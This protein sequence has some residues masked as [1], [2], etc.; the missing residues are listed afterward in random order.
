[1]QPRFP[2]PSLSTGLHAA[3]PFPPGPAATILICL[4]MASGAVFAIAAR[5]LLHRA[6]L[7]FDSMRADVLAH[8][9]ATLHFALAWWACCLFALGAFLVG[10]LCGAATHAIVGRRLTRPLW[11]A[12]AIAVLGLAAVAQ[13]RSSPPAAAVATN[14]A[15]SLLVM[16][17]SAV[18]ALLGAHLLGGIS[19]NPTATPLRARLGGR[20]RHL[21]GSI[22]CPAAR[23]KSEGSANCG[24]PP[25]RARRRHQRV[26]QS[27]SSARAALVTQLAIVVFAPV[28]VLAGSTVALHLSNPA[29]TTRAGDLWRMTSTS[30]ASEARSRPQTLSPTDEGGVTVPVA[31]EAQPI[32]NRVEVLAPRARQISIAI[33]HGAALS[34]RD[35]TFTKGYPQR[36]AAQLAAGLISQPAIPLPTAAATV[37]R[38]D[39]FQQRLGQEA[40][41]PPAAA[42]SRPRIPRHGQVNGR[43]AESR[44]KHGE[45]RL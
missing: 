44:R 42:E 26:H 10:P 6:G 35:L 1:M 16:I 2:P 18:L 17:G 37:A 14:A 21:Q 34:E 33:G 43:Y 24:L 19:R 12:T 38:N 13:L 8:R 45:P 3:G 31:T 28:S 29:G 9:A 36:R 4:V 40:R 7:D 11:S 41:M 23:L 27:F 25:R 20:L 32:P 15:V 30:S 22:A 5:T 39:I